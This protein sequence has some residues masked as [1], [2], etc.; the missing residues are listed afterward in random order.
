MAQAVAI[1]GK[2][3]RALQ[4]MA[5]AGKI[6]SGRDRDSADHDGPDSQIRSW[7]AHRLPMSASLTESTATICGRLGAVTTY[8]R[9]G[10]PAFG[11]L[12][13]TIEGS[14]RRV[15]IGA[16]ASL[17]LQHGCHVDTLRRALTRNSDDSASGPLA[18]ALDLMADP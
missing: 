8:R 18:R 10:K 9:A 7:R 11:P 13:D 5:L 15:S 14:R 2:S 3:E 12:G 1:T 6:S 17:L 4:G 16:A